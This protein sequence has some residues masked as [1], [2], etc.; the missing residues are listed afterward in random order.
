MFGGCVVWTFVGSSSWSYSRY[1]WWMCCLNFCRVQFLVLLP[2]YL[3][4][5]LSEPLKGPVPGLTPAMFSGCVV[6]TFVGSS[7]WFYSHYIWWMCCLN[8]YWVQF[9]VLLPLYLMDVQT[10]HPPNITGVK[11]GTGPYK[12]SDNTSTK[13]S[14]SK[15]RNWTL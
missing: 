9:L 7:S 1:V 5:V 14:W 4:D 3:V 2:L 10:T 8:F 11:P 6:W 12:S 15:T 13:H